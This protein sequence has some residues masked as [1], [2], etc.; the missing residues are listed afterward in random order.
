ME[1]QKTR[2]IDLT[3]E[4]LKSLISK[5]VAQ[6]NKKT[7]QEQTVK[8]SK[9]EQTVLSIKQV[10]SLLQ[11]SDVTLWRYDSKN[12]LKKRRNKGTGKVFYLKSD[13]ET[14]LNPVV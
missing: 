1:L 10:C 9:E 4:D 7:T 13:L 12:I 3:V 8:T 2:L 14:F 5:I 6:E 11:I